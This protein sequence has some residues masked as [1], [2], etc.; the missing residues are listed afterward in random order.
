MY[1]IDSIRD[2][3]IQRAIVVKKKTYYVVAQLGRIESN[4]YFVIDYML[5]TIK[6][7]KTNVLFDLVFTI[8]F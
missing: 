1:R 3:P 8:K 4:F 2:S 5:E 6:N 7:R